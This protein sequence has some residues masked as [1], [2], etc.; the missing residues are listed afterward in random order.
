MPAKH[1]IQTVD[2]LIF[3]C[4][5]LENDRDILKNSVL[6]KGNWPLSKS[7]LINRNF[8]QFIGYINSMDFEKINRSNEQL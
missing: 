2:H 6:I 8:K 7:E 4:E 3:Q 5:R 1:D